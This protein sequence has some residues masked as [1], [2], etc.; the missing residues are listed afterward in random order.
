[1]LIWALYTRHRQPCLWQKLGIF[2]GA[3]TLSTRQG[4]ESKLFV[5]LG[6][7]ILFLS[8]SSCLVMIWSGASCL[9]SILSGASFWL[10]YVQ[11]LV[12]FCTTHI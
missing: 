8:G 9:D 2:Y 12:V 3:G 7:W 1:M 10:L 5:G 11:V 4:F 6:V